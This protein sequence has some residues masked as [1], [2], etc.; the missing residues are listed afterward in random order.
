MLFS[1]NKWASIAGSVA[2]GGGGGGGGGDAKFL[3]VYADPAALEA[4]HPQAS[5]VIGSTAGVTSTSTMWF[6]SGANV[7]TDSAIGFLGDMLKSVYDS[8]NLGLNV[9][10]KANETGVEQITGTIITP[11]TL[12]ATAD[13]YSPVGFATTNMIRQDI[14]ANQRE[15]TGFPAPA[16][17]VARI[18]RINNISTGGFD[19]RLMH[20]N[21]GSLAANRILLRD[22]NDKDIKPNETGGLWYDHTSVRWRAF[23]RVG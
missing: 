10:D 3:G 1:L 14:D 2:F 7:W 9:Y 16:L 20:N 15:I 23:T 21:A 11:A 8:G 18:I 19:L 6:V 12:T 22:D 4:A 17:G 5:Q 13:D